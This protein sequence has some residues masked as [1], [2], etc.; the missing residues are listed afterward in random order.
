MSYSRPLIIDQI[1]DIIQVNKNKKLPYSIISLD[2]NIGSG[3]STLL[4]MLKKEY[5]ENQNIVFLDEPVEE[6]NTIIDKN[7][8]SILEKFYSNPSKYAFCFQMMAYITRLVNMKKSIETHGINKIYITERSLYTDKIVF[9]KMLYDSQQIEEIEYN[10]YLRWFDEFAKEY[11]LSAVIYIN[12]CPEKCKERIQHRSRK[13]EEQIPLDYLIR[14]DQYHQDMMN[15]LEC[16]KLEYNG[17]I[18][19]VF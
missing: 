15:Q 17:N 11:P 9:A 5:K 8:I 19:I 6:W 3:K 7:G 10:V 1:N 18:D 2:G 4:N 14:C 12:T 16:M 13:G